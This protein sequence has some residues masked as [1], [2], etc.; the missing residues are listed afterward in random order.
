[1][2]RAKI[3]LC[4]GDY[5]RALYES[6]LAEASQPAPAKAIVNVYMDDGCV[7]VDV[8]SENVSKLRAVLNSYMYLIYAA[9]STLASTSRSQ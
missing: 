7:V 1:M 3:R 4:L 5:S 8:K 2:K 9:L 6:L